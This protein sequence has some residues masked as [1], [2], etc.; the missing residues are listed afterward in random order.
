[1]AITTPMEV[2]LQYHGL[3]QFSTFHFLKQ[4]A[5]SFILVKIRNCPEFGNAIT[6]SA[7]NVLQKNEL[8]LG[9]LDYLINILDIFLNLGTSSLRP[10][11]HFKKMKRF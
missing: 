5:G 10:Q 11:N 3:L 8:I 2:G 4:V 9:Y 7:R 6:P 1:M